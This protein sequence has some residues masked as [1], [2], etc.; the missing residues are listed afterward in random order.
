[1]FLEARGIRNAIVAA[2][3]GNQR[4]RGT[5]DQNFGGESEMLGACRLRHGEG[6][7]NGRTQLVL[8]YAE[9]NELFR[10][11]PT[12]RVGMRCPPCA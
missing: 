10:S 5:K 2:H 11:E 8:Y 1:M 7:G 12:P 4:R 6:G 9:L 3:G